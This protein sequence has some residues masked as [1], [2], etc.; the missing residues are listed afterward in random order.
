MK[1]RF[2]LKDLRHLV[3]VLILVFLS[4]FLGYRR[5]ISKNPVSVTEGKDLSLFWYVW[6]RLEEK[7]LEK[8]KIDEQLM[9]EGAISGMVDAL[10]DPYT[11]FLPPEDN[12]VNK[13]DLFGEFGGV[14]IQLGYKDKI[15]AV[16]APLKQT[17]AEKAGIK[18]GDLILRIKDDLADVDQPT[19]SL[20]LPEAVKLIRGAEGTKVVLTIFREGL[21]KPEDFELVRSK[22]DIP[23]FESGWQA[24]DGKNFAHIQLFQFSG[25][26]SEEWLGWVNQT[27]SQQPN[28]DGI[29]LDL[30]N[31]PGGYLEESVFVAGEFLPR[32][33]VVVWQEDYLGRKGKF[34]V[35]RDGRFLN[36]PLV[37]LVNQGS[38]S[39]SEILAGALK[40]HQRAKIIGT[41]TFG[42]GIVQEPEELPNRAGLHITTARWLLPNGG[43]IHEVGVDPDI[44]VTEEV[45]EEF[46]PILEKGIETLLGVSQ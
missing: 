7:F 38:S 27:V 41:T 5:G 33:D 30:R 36:A 9:I 2:S 25:Q 15:L 31:N 26:L 21:E 34:S 22:I 10:D 42:K 12:K 24:R 4:G 40:D 16:I 19:D 43:S 23:S 28:L 32:G 45:S 6:G 3:F 39:A 13:E 37:V 14:G 44:E 17:P 11:V 46:D 8:D 29:I 35:E 20:S 18:A 1:I